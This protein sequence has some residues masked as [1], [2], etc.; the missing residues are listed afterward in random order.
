MSDALSDEVA[1]QFY[2]N[3]PTALGLLKVLGAPQGK[4][5]LQTAA[6]S[7]LGRMLIQLAKHQGVRTINVVRR[8]GAVEELKA[9]G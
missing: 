3:P 4:W 2:V 9:L 8:R 1:A 5:V 6:A 7:V